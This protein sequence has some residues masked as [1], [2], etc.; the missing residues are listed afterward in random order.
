MSNSTHT[1]LPFLANQWKGVTKLFR[2]SSQ[3]L[4]MGT[5]T[6]AYCTKLPLGNEARVTQI[7]LSPQEPHDARLISVVLTGSSC[8]SAMVQT[9]AGGFYIVDGLNCSTTI[10]QYNASAIV[11]LRCVTRQMKSQQ[12]KKNMLLPTCASVL[13]HVIQ[14]QGYSTSSDQRRHRQTKK[15]MFRFIT[16]LLKPLAFKWPCS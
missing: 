6:F 10:F 13:V 2:H 5:Q 7:P 12:L 15:S 8:L 11:R 1:L 16:V 3:S 4:T 14:Q 9:Q